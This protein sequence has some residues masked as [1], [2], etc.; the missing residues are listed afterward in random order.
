MPTGQYERKPKDL[1]SEFKKRVD[2]SGECWEWTGH[3]QTQGY[4][5]VQV[6]AKLWTAHRLAWTLY[7]GPIPDGKLICHSCDNPGCVN[8]EHLFLGTHADNMEDMVAKNRSKGPEWTEEQRQRR[9]QASREW[10]QNAT[11]AEK[12]AI[13]KAPRGADGRFKDAE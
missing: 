9:G 2:R 5:Q 4:G 11:A 1:A 10:W 6:N 7:N 3:R 13:Q 8:P 12:A